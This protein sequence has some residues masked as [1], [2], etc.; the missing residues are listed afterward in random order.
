MDFFLQPP[1]EHRLPPEEVRLRGLRIIP[2]SHGNKV[3]VNLELH[4]FKKRPNIEVTIF[5]A[6]GKEVA[7]TNILEAMQPKMEFIMHIRA[8][9]PGSQYRVETCVYYQQLP[10]P[11]ETQAEV[12]IPEPM[13]VDR[14]E[15][16]FVLPLLDT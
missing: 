16:I 2:H 10:G 3:K 11:S 7:H 15:V 12:P 14:G 9:V 4:P 5:D 6:S 13:I 8:P 1:D